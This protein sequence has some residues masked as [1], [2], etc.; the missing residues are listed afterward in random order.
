MK[1]PY[2]SRRSLMIGA[3]ALSMT[4]MLASGAL[5]EAPQLGTQIPGWYRFKIGEIEA[6][7]ISDGLLNLGS[8][9]D[10]FPAAPQD[11]IAEIMKAEFLPVEPMML[12]QNCIVLNRG[13]RLVLIDSGM[14]KDEMFGNGAGRLL[15]NLAAASITPEQ[16][17]DIVLTH[18]HPDHCWGLVGAD[19]SPLFPNAMLHLSQV[20][21]D[22]WTDESKLSAEGFLPAFVAGARRNLLPYRERMNFVSDGKEALPGITAIA[23]PGHTLGHMSYIISSGDEAFL[24]VGD[25]CHHYALLF[26]N[27]GWEFAFDTDPGLAAKTRLRLFDM[28][29]TEALPMIGYHFP[30]P[31]LGNIRRAGSAY[32]YVPIALSHG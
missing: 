14:G 6:T 17:D 32:E 1:S 8:A 13:G 12:E 31:G 3:G 27:P 2:I 16:I 23:T 19:G 22:F 24:N 29:A 9:N 10:Q 21:F 4:P 26:E 7:I 18:A 30:F 25:V 28:A 20:D 11:Q 5:A 15:R